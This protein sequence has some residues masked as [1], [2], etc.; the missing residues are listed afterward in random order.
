MSVYGT[1]SSPSRAQR[2]AEADDARTHEL[3]GEFARTLERRRETASEA[4]A[5][6]RGSSSFDDVAGDR[7][8]ERAVRPAD[9]DR[10]RDRR[11]GEPRE[12]PDASSGGRPG[13][14]VAPE[15]GAADRRT[16]PDERRS[17]VASRRGP[18][19]AGD[20]GAGA[21]PDRASPES[22]RAR[23]ADRGERVRSAVREALDTGAL[24]TDAERSS[25]DRERGAAETLDGRARARARLR[26]ADEWTHDVGGHHADTPFDVARAFDRLPPTADEGQAAARAPAGDDPGRWTSR[27]LGAGLAP[28]GALAELAGRIVAR[29]AEGDSGPGAK[30]PGAW[31]FSLLEGDEE[32]LAF[33]LTRHDGGDVTIALEE[34]AGD[35]HCTALLDELAGRLST[36]GEPVSLERPLG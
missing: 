16:A 14:D 23:A 3:A 28:S 2:D 31:R 32:S 17:S 26:E 10:G 6:T 30:R 22:A 36:L 9:G 5:A 15:A 4:A 1:I 21:G 12:R 19:G 24:A 7:A 11:A 29:L 27:A 35:R 34:D 25:A 8:T 13:E 20:E 18:S 33:V